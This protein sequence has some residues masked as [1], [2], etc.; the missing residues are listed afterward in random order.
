MADAFGYFHHLQLQVFEFD[1]YRAVMSAV[2]VDDETGEVHAFAKGSVE[3]LA[4]ICEAGSV[5]PGYSQTANGYASDGVRGARPPGSAPM[6]GP[7]P[8][9]SFAARVISVRYRKT[10]TSSFA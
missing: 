5:P 4:A 9:C 7:L 1:H 8:G 10:A 2:A 3:R 6:H